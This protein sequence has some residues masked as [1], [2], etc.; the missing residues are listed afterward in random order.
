MAGRLISC[1]VCD[2]SRLRSGREIEIDG[3]HNSVL[4]SSSEEESKS[5]MTMPMLDCETCWSSKD[6]VGRRT[7]RLRFV[8]R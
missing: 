8:P 2:E 1:C 4:S 5:V 6:H 3:V 7:I